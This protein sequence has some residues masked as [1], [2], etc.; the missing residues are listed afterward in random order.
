MTIGADPT[1][2]P[3]IILQGLSTTDPALLVNEM[4]QTKQVQNQSALI[5]SE[6]AKNQAIANYE[7]FNAG[8]MPLGSV[9]FGS[10]AVAAKA[11]TLKNGNTYVPPSEA[12]NDTAPITPTTTSPH[13]TIDPNTGEPITAPIA[14]NSSPQ[15][16]IN[17]DD[18]QYTESLSG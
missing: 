4:N 8:I 12:T 15:S 17:N 10:H 11:K 16:A 2:N 13:P 1:L 7:N 18:D 6:I 14:D 3:E 9:N 5:P